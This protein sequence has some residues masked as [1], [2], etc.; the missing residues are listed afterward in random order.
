[1]RHYTE[2]QFK[3]AVRTSFSIHQTMLTLGMNTQ[4]SAYRS[5]HSAVKEWSVDTSHF[6]GQL[7]SKGRTLQ[8]KRD[9]SVYLSNEYKID[10]HKLKL[11]LF[12]EN[13]LTKQCAICGLTE[14]NDKEIPLELDHING[15]H[16]DNS[17]T[18]L[19]AICP[20]CHAQTD[21]HAGKNK[22]KK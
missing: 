15:N 8:P 4:G 12:K 1:M 6:T 22:R 7:W 20:N 9:I 10:S 14:W 13:L 16:E 5:F 11:R 3:E 17:L 2:E 18:N 21:T 19:R